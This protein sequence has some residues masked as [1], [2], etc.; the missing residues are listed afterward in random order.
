[1]IKFKS[2]TTNSNIALLADT[3]VPSV[4]VTENDDSQRRLPVSAEKEIRDLDASENFD[5]FITGEIPPILSLCMS[6]S[7][8]I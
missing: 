8:L 3:N 1:M 2:S 7:D 6:S 4:D 5:H